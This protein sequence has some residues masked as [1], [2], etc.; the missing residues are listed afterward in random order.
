MVN[1]ALFY[2]MLIKIETWQLD[3]CHLMQDPIFVLENS[4]PLD[5]Q[6]YLENQLSKPLMRIFE[7]ILGEKKAESTLLRKCTFT[8]FVFMLESDFK[9]N[10]YVRV[11]VN[12]ALFRQAGSIH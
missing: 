11:Q 7:P 3:M 6:Y 2:E 12:V 4:V 5:T 1:G 10:K 9:D 8:F